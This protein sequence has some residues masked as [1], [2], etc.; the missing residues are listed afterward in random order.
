M[1]SGNIY[2]LKATGS[3]STVWSG[4]N[5]ENSIE[6]RQKALFENCH[7]YLYFYSTY[8]EANAE[9]LEELFPEK[10][11]Y[12]SVVYD[13][14]GKIREEKETELV[15][16]E[17]EDN[18]ARITYPLHYGEYSLLFCFEADFIRDNNICPDIA[19]GIPAIG[20]L[21]PEMIQN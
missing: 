16:E 1:K 6:N 12:N 2:Y 7:E 19:I 9:M 20:E 3:Y 8:Y 14:E 18:V 15:R 17:I 5:G 10:E 4:W 13:V 11:A 21:V